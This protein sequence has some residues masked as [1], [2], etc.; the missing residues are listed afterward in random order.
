MIN[1][2]RDK[3]IQTKQD[4]PSYLWRCELALNHIHLVT[5]L[6]LHHLYN[7]FCNH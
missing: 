6:I 2:Q 7:H 5:Y 3:G 4:H 1:F